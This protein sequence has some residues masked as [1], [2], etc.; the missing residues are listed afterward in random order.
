MTSSSSRPSFVAKCS[1]DRQAVMVNPDVTRAEIAGLADECLA[2]AHSGGDNVAEKFAT[3]GLSDA[4]TMG[5]YGLSKALVNMYTLQLARENPSLI[6]NACTPGMIKTDLA[7]KLAAKF[8]KS[9]EEMGAKSPAEGAEV[10]V[11]LANGDVASSGWYFGSDK[12]RSPL[13]RYRNPGSP[14]YDGK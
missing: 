8:D 6:V 10:L 13:D 7:E 5:G 11:Y 9:L 12:Q 1:A 14:P 2:I 3:A 4:Q